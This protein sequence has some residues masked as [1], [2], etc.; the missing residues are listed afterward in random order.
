MRAKVVERAAARALRRDGRAIRQIADTLGVAQSSVSVWVR[1]I[2]PD[3]PVAEPAPIIRANRPA[4][5]AGATKCCARC[6]TMKSVAEFNRNGTGLTAWCRD[7]Y[8]TYHQG[9]RAERRAVKVKQLA[10]A[11]AHVLSV[12]ARAHCTDCG[13]CDA[14]V[15]EFD[16]VEDKQS[17]IT[18]LVSGAANPR[19]LDEEIAR[20]EIVC[21]N[22][23]RRRT[24]LRAGH[25][26][27]LTRWWEAPPPP[28]RTRARN[29]AVMYSWL[30]SAGCADCGTR[31]LCVLEFDHVR[32]K[33]GNVSDLARDG[34]SVARLRAEIARCEVRCANCHRRRTA[35][36]WGH[37]RT[38]R[39][40][41]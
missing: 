29:T 15:M 24:A 22:C 38:H 14:V 25:R 37:Y 10:R 26:R 21:V 17:T 32:G 6:Q 20:C 31:E 30:E 1:D 28:G 5:T 27:S 35:A 41:S 18:R 11:R 9:R 33:T 19:R 7:C 4:A 3:A 12:V 8:R 16:H 2:V 34:C 39:G 36:D 40:A 23:H 13:L